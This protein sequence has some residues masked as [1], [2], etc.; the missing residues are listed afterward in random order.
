VYGN[1]VFL[2]IDINLQYFAEKLAGEAFES[3][4]RTR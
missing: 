3:T 1:Q 4:R 2:T